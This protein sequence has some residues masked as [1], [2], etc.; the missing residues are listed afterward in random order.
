MF[1][2]RIAGAHVVMSYRVKLGFCKPRLEAVYS[3][4]EDEDVN[5][6]VYISKVA[7]VSVFLRL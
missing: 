7:F 5:G 3:Y 4:Q 2:Y 6:K 1:G